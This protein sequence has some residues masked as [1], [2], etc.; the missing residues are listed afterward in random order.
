MNREEY[1]RTLSGLLSGRMS[2]GELENVMNYY[3][4]YFDEAEGRS[5][6]EIVEEL[7]NPRDLA[8]QILGSRAGTARPEMEEVP[9]RRMSGGALVALIC[10]SPIWVPLS[11][12][13]L[14]AAF[15]LVVG[16]AAGG[17]ACVGAGLYVVWQGFTYVFQSVG[18]MVF[19]AGVGLF[20]SG[21]G[22]LL[23]LGGLWLGAA[24]CRG[25]ARLFRKLGG[26]RGGSAV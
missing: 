1:L 26:Q 24:V 16:L 9:R 12:G 14:S 17:V 18:A 22:V 20:V 13:L 3:S 4:E 23:T 25:L 15:A 7:G 19:L 8:A 10:L 6:S 5:E 11:L 2:P 21:V